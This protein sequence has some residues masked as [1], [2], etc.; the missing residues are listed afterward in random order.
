[1]EFDLEMLLFK[2]QHDRRM[3]SSFLV[4]ACS[5]TSAFPAA[6]AAQLAV[7]DSVVSFVFVGSPIMQ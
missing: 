2:I 4:L 7:H 3:Y 5:L 1:M 6:A